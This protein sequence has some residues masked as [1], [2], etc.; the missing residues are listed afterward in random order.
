MNRV[1]RTI[2]TWPD[3]ERPREKLLMLGPGVLGPAE[4]LAILIRTGTSGGRTAL[5]VAR[6]LWMLGGES[7]EGLAR[8]GATEIGVVSGMGPAKAAT[9][10]AALEIGRRVGASPLAERSPVNDGRS[11]FEHFRSRLQH[12]ERERFYALLLDSRSRLLRE[13]L[14]SEGSLTESLVHPREAFRTAIREGAAAVVFVHNHPSGDPAP[15]ASDIKLT[16]RLF[17]AGKLLGIKVVDHVI[18]ARSG[19]YSFFESVPDDGLLR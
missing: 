7:W 1:D 10:A 9:I 6:A 18:I 11:V 5:D 19:F 13:E 12:L 16:R 14:I 4:L 17:E 8:L 3:E 15:G 2:P